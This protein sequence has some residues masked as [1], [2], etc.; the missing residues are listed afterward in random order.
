MKVHVLLNPA[1]AGGAALERWRRIEGR[2]RLLFPDLSL[3][4]S[5]K[6]GDLRQIAGELASLD[7]L[8][9]A[10][11]GDGTSHEVVNG[12][13][14]RRTASAALTAPRATM[15]WLPLGSGNDLARSQGIPLDGRRALERYRRFDSALID[16]GRLRYRDEQGGV[17]ERVFGNSLTFGLSANVLALTAARGKPLGG[18]MSYFLATLW[19]L[20]RAPAARLGIDGA[21]ESFRLVSITNGTCFGAGM[22][23][24]PTACLDDGALDLLTVAA[25]PR[26]ETALLFPRIY[27]GGHLRHRAVRHRHFR[28]TTIT[29]SGP[30]AFEADGELFAGHSPFEI[31]VLPRALRVARP[32]VESR[33]R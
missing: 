22:R 14:D 30:L 17:V 7:A 19:A 4:R 29:A 12:L 28:A 25:V 3:H 31:A 16:V 23:I 5:Q 32:T 33:T 10:A 8:V 13:L 6:P 21:E 2:A 26:L 1:G 15:G 24:T 11:G 27:W 18:R 20:A 9:L